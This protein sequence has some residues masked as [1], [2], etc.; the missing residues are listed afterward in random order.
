MVHLAG[1]GR[2][3]PLIT[4]AA[5]TTAT[6]EILR[7]FVRPGHRTAGL[8]WRLLQDATERANA[9]GFRRLVLNT[10]PSMS[11]ARRL[12]DANGYEPIEAYVAEPVDGV[13]FLGR[14][15]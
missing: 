10:L 2:T 3:G 11:A 9:N 14:A 13:Q 1:R 5:A 7:L 4:R 15:L 8:G 12:Y 6:G